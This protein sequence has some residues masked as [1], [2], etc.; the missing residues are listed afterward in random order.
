MVC[1][2]LLRSALCLLR[3][4]GEQSGKFTL[5][6][7]QPASIITRNEPAADLLLSGRVFSS[8]RLTPSTLKSP[9]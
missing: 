2:H 6:V 7:S 9:V 8:I 5:L 1:A 3:Q 4:G